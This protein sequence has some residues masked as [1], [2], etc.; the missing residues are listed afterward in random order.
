MRDLISGLLGRR[1]HRRAPATRL[2]TPATTIAD[3]CHHYGYPHRRDVDLH[4]LNTHFK[5]RATI[6]EPT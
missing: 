2:R 6:G 5:I 3:A 1:R 4:E